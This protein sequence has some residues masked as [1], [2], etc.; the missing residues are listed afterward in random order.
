MHREG[1]TKNQEKSWKQKQNKI[2]VKIKIK[3]TTTTTK[4]KTYMRK[5]YTGLKTHN[6]PM[7]ADCVAIRSDSNMFHGFT[8]L[9]NNFCGKAFNFVRCGWA[10][11]IAFQG[12]FEHWRDTSVGSG[13]G[14]LIR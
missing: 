13:R 7:V 11:S 4:N 8:K 10:S 6:T 3:K 9:S 5:Q 1:K 12:F 2:N 14:R